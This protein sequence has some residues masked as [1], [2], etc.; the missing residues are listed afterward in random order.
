MI[1]TNHFLW[2]LLVP[3]NTLNHILSNFVDSEDEIS[4]FSTSNYVSMA[5]IQSSFQTRQSDFVNAT[6]NIQS[7][8]AQFDNLYKIMNDL[9]TSG[10]YFG[11]I[12]LQETW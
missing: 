8:N 12:R 6:P 2:D 4:N 1:T 11:A 9:S 5:D 7:I 3:K 10:Q